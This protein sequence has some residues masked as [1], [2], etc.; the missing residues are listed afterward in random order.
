MPKF[1]LMAWL[2]VTVFLLYNIF[3]SLSPSTSAHFHVNEITT[4][5][6]SN[7]ELISILTPPAINCVCTVRSAMSVIN[8][9]F[10]DGCF[11]SPLFTTSLCL[12]KNDSQMYNNVAI[13]NQKK[14]IKSLYYTYNDAYHEHASITHSLSFISSF[15]SPP[16]F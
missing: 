6:L 11:D 15:L 3:L 2:P 16:A 14:S 9:Q 12:W 4:Y 1:H 10:L 5:T 7:R 13:F 8:F